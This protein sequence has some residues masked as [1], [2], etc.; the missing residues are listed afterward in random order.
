MYLYCMVYW[1]VRDNAVTIQENPI[2][3]QSAVF[4]CDLKSQRKGH[5]LI[6][7]GREIG[8]AMVRLHDT[9]DKGE[10]E[11]NVCGKFASK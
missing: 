7:V 4:L 10:P 8:I 11:S 2:V 9:F 5:A 1:F 6:R 3:D